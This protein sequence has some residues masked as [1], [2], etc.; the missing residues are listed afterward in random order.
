[1]RIRIRT[2]QKH[3]D[4]DPKRWEKAFEKQSVPINMWVVVLKEHH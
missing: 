3:A 1:M 4:P 2:G